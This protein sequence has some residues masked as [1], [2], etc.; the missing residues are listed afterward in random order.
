M[1]NIPGP[2]ATNPKSALRERVGAAI[3]DA[4]A[5][6]LA[7]HEQASMGEVAEAA[8]V[9]RATLYRYFP[10]RE[11]LLEEL[12]RTTVA[13]V[14]Q[15]LEAGRLDEL[16]VDEAFLRAVRA[17]VAIGDAFVVVARE[18]DA[19]QAQDFEHVVARPL[20][21][22]VERGQAS[23]DLRDDVPSGWLLQSLLALVV[24]VL[25]SAPGLGAEDAVQT[26]ASLFLTGAHGR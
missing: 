14:A 11:A 7:R 6:A 12:A 20:R 25:P 1:S 13:R 19:A 10:T 8:G 21:A 22:L 4:A 2:M 24:S 3:I 18:R 5:T 17:L 26:I 16:A 23:G 9:A 15:A